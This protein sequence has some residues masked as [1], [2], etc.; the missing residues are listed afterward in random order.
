MDDTRSL[1]SDIVRF[2]KHHLYIR[3][4]MLSWQLA[5]KPSSAM[6]GQKWRCTQ[7]PSATDLCRT[8][9]H[10]PCSAS[11]S[12][13]GCI[14][15]YLLCRCFC[16]MAAAEAMHNNTML[17]TDTSMTLC[18]CLCLAH[19]AIRLH[20]SV[21]PYATSFSRCRL[22]SPAQ[23]RVV[24]LTARSCKHWVSRHRPLS[25]KEEPEHITVATL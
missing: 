3:C 7:L 5:V 12:P 2:G 9:C 11:P 23:E 21:N 22:Q 25:W 8:S 14:G 20:T 10:Q 24:L 16:T 18:T 6:P 17:L 15:L 13:S 19:T 1:Q 4:C